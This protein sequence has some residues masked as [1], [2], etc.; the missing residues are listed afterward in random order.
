[1]E[2]LERKSESRRP[3][4]DPQFRTVV[5]TIHQIAP[6]QYQYY[7]RRVEIIVAIEKLA[8]TG[9]FSV[10]PPLKLVVKNQMRT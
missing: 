6:L 2:V 5:A 4:L 1:M 3:S 9:I 7:N 8:E 10:V